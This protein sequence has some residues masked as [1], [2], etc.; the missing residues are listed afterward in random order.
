MVVYCSHVEVDLITGEL[1]NKA[2]ELNGVINQGHL[3]SCS[4]R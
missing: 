4:F 2:L 3:Q 1:K